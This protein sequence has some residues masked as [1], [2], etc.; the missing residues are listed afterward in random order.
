MSYKSVNHYRHTV[1]RYLDAIWSTS[2]AKKKARTSM[3]NWLAIQMNIPT[4]ECH[5]SMFNANKQ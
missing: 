5:V 1:H 4:E 3:Y 2:S